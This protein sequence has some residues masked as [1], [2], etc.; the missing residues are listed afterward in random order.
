MT[1][2]PSD[3]RGQS[4]FFWLGLAV[5]VVILGWWGRSPLREIHPA[6]SEIWGS[7]CYALLLFC[8]AASLIPR[9]VAQR[10]WTFSVALAVMN[11]TIEIVQAWPLEFLEQLRATSA[12]RWILGTTFSTVDLLGAFLG[13]VVGALLVGTLPPKR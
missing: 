8:G 1:G 4:R 5:V 12:G 6:L 13:V 9:V 3:R 7:G 10:P 2:E 11:L